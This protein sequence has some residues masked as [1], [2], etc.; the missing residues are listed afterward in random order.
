MQNSSRFRWLHLWVIPI[1]IFLLAFLPRAIYPVSRSLLWYE[2]AIEFTDALLAR[3]WAGTWRRYHPGVTVMWLSG[4]GLKVFAWQRGLSS[5]Q[6]LGVEPTHPGTV[7]NA[8]TAGVLP[9]AIA[10]ALGI[11]LSYLLLRRLT[12]PKIAFAGGCL[13]ALDPFHIM[14]S[15][16]LHLDS[17][18]AMLMFVS[19]LSFLSY[20]RRRR[21]A[22]LILSGASAGLA[23]LTKSP[24]LFLVP[25]VMLAV[26][27]HRLMSPRSRSGPAARR[28]EWPQWLLGTVRVL[29]AW[30][31]VVVLVFVAI[32][33][34]MWVEPLSVLDRM[35]RAAVEHVEEPHPRPNFFNGR[36]LLEDPGLTFYLATIA[37]KTTLVTLPM[38]CAALPLTLLRLRRRE[39]Y[40]VV[41]SLAAYAAFFTLQ[42]GLGSKKGLRYLLPAFPALDVLAAVG[43][44]QSAE[45]LS[46]LRWWRGRGWLSTALVVLA[47]VAQASIV[48]PHHPY[49]GTHYNRLLGGIGV[50][51]RVLPL[52]D[53]CEGLDLAGQYLNTL[54]HAQ[55]ARAVV[56]KSCASLFGRNF[57]GHASYVEEPWTD[58]RI[59][60]I[61]QVMRRFNYDEW[62]E[63][64]EADQESEPLWTKELNG[65]VYVWIYG[66]PPGELAVAGP[67]FDM[68]FRL[69]EHIMLKRVRLSSDVLHPGDSLVVVLFWESDGKVRGDYV[70]FSHLLSPSGGLAAQHDGRPIRGV[71]PAPSW[72]AGEV[73]EDGHL[74]QLGDDLAPG[75]YELSVGMYDPE[76]M[77]RVPAYDA[78]GERLPEDRVIVG[79]V[80]VQVPDTPAR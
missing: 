44:V 4:I 48:L 35:V 20:L 73:I 1:L 11:V 12:D 10:V 64:W 58:Y 49:Y 51:Q 61:N 78:S 69:G 25:Y 72:R 41:W 21:W 74:L 62:G 42:M 22:D 9:L 68:G 19:A 23:F 15:K 59:Y 76:T 17:L 65:V 31:G 26:G 43:L 55:R 40:S 18:L 54:P 24:S 38:A 56:Q 80:R 8:V 36:I 52:Q 5:D 47:L 67:E 30:G 77:Q 57:V 37:W 70:V 71:R 53:Q 28:G 39:G 45:L 79:M 16:V 27:V 14:H 46:H 60:F 33:P 29:L 75:E 6:L 66:D 34:A 50:A 2:R 3:D 32:W 13:L 7:N 63:A